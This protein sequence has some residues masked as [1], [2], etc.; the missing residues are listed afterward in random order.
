M[1]LSELAIGQDAIITSVE[2]KDVS[3]RKHIL[4]MGLT[5]GVE[6]SLL[7]C[8][9]LGD[10]IEIQLRGYNLTLRKSD[11]EN[12]NISGVHESDAP[13]DEEVVRRRIN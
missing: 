3:L 4:E 8:A 13:E 1:K 11:A 6:V 2:T 7:K 9:P 5:P 12:I 10:P